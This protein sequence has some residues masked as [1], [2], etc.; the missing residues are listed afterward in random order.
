MT[1]EQ[2]VFDPQGRAFPNA[3]R[4]RPRY[5][6]ER[7]AG[8]LSKFVAV[9]DNAFSVANGRRVLPL[10][11]PD[12]DPY[13]TSTGGPGIGSFRDTPWLRHLPYFSDILEGLPAPVR[14]ARLWAAAPGTEARDMRAPKIGPPWGFCR[15][16]LPIAGGPLAR[17]LFV[18]EQQEWR[19][20]TL[21]FAA[22]WRSHTIV[23]RDTSDLVHL[24]VD[25]FHT[26]ETELL[27]PAHLRPGTSSPRALVHRPEIPL[28][29]GEAQR[30][31]SRFK[32]PELFTN[33][34]CAGHRVR[35][36]A[37]GAD[38]EAEIAVRRG[39]LVLLLAGRL[40]CGLE[41]VG[42]GEFRLRSWSDERTLQVTPAPRPAAVL[43]IREGSNT[44]VF[45]LPLL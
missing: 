38:I 29:A 35:S 39:S 28:S 13:R 34:E 25:V 18:G 22:S 23:N 1:I 45:E 16:H 27:F 6:A 3:V 37:S 20:G 4:L 43:R 36:G 7:M 44:Y 5:D 19:P 21:W 32:L 33:W 8:E 9:S 10:R 2:H 30:Y 15:L 26:A 24:I 42:D 12:G 14:G 40:F 17:C 41:H 31:R 11:S